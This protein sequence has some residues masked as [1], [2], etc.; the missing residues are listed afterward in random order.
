M[1][2]F[3][4]FWY[5]LQW[6]ESQLIRKMD[7]SIR[8]TDWCNNQCE[9][10][11]KSDVF[12]EVKFTIVSVSLYPGQT[13]SIGSVKYGRVDNLILLFSTS[14]KYNNKWFLD[15]TAVCSW[16]GL[17]HYAIINQRSY[18]SVLQIFLLDE[19]FCATCWWWWWLQPSN[20]AGA[21][22]SLEMDF[23]TI[24]ATSSFSL[25]TNKLSI[26]LVLSDVNVVSLI[27]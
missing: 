24:A 19:I 1:N 8:A 4:D 21:S 10:W 11:Q 13:L 18:F 22:S 15:D 12:G 25:W 7:T 20:G 26:C 9:W 16:A 23:D 27:D 2:F 17:L 3:H 6:L 14:K 5:I